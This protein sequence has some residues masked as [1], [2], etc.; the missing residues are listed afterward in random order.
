MHT[1]QERVP[2]AKPSEWWAM[3]E[4]VFDLNWGRA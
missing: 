3:M 2:E 1:M 4:L